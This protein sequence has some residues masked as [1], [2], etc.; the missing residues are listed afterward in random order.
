MMLY[1]PSL[2]VSRLIA[3]KNSSYMYD[4]DFHHG[5]N[6]LSGCNGGGKTSIIQLLVFGMGYEVTNWKDEA[7]ACDSVYVGLKVNGIDITI[8]RDINGKEKQP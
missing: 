5:I 6:I 2:R 1:N 4:E 3:T 7:G 8:K